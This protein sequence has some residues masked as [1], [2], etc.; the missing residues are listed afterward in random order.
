MERPA[1]QGFA[2]SLLLSFSLLGLPFGCFCDESSFITQRLTEVEYY[3]TL[4]RV[5]HRIQRNEVKEA[6][7]I[8]KELK[9]AKGAHSYEL[10]QQICRDLVEASAHSSRPMA[11]R[12][13]LLASASSGDESLQTVFYTAFDSSDLATQLFALHL[14]H[15]SCHPFTESALK[16][17]LNAAHPLLRLEA[18]ALLIERGEVTALRHLE[19][20]MVKLP[21]ELQ[22]LQ[23][24]LL[25]QIDSQEA[26]RLLRRLLFHP[27]SEV[28]VEAIHAIEQRKI[29]GLMPQLRS[30]VDHSSYQVKEAA[31]AALARLADSSA[32]KEIERYTNHPHPPTAFAAR[33]AIALLT[34]GESRFLQKE[35]EQGSLWALHSLERD[36]ENTKLLKRLQ[37]HPQRL[38]R[39]NAAIALLE[40]HVLPDRD[41]LFDLFNASA[42]GVVWL[43][44]ASEGKAFKAYKQAALSALPSEQREMAH[45]AALHVT[46]EWLTLC[47]ECGQKALLEI[48]QLLIDNRDNSLVPH[49]FGLFEKNPSEQVFE[50]MQ[51]LIYA[52][53]Y[54]LV[55]Y[56][57]ALSLAKQDSEAKSWLLLEEWLK[58]NWKKDLLA[59]RPSLSIRANRQSSY[60]LQ[61]TEEGQLFIAILEAFAERGDEKSIDLLLQGI[62]ES[63]CNQTALVAALLLRSV[64]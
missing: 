49:L 45:E 11:L 40:R 17:T 60:K 39:S 21:L 55:R 34:K 32:L 24:P 54:P 23:A 42:E 15:Q 53:G 19:A 46:Q 27:M 56:Y 33:Y 59:F 16:Q 44:I 13:A 3:S 37:K 48:G 18:I 64:L 10:L 38:V 47:Q 30:C 62:E 28:A 1:R 36:E 12:I 6:I 25:A 7:A 14:L 20:F 26:L 5:R 9:K 63:H 58:S 22:A 41:L 43:P 31:M 2:R 29:T 50:L 4:H 52:P 61:P 51:K 8:Y 57:S 35:A